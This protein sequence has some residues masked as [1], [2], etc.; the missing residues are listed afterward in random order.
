M[1][2]VNPQDLHDFAR[3]DWAAVATS[4]AEHWARCKKEHGWA[5]AVR[6]AAMLRRQIVVLRPGWPSEEDRSQDLA[7]HA[8]VADCLRR[9][10]VRAG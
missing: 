1:R 10:S 4:K 8:R 5:D 9:V 6:A 3:R 7:T 2:F